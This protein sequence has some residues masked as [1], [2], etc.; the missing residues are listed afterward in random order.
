[1]VSIELLQFNFIVFSCL[2]RAY[3]R[4][5]EESLK[6]KYK[7]IDDTGSWSW[8][9]NVLDFSESLQNLLYFYSKHVPEFCGQFCLPLTP[10]HKNW[11]PGYALVTL[12]ELRGVHYHMVWKNVSFML[13]K[14]KVFFAITCG[15][16]VANK[17]T[18]QKSIDS[19]QA[20][21]NKWNAYSF[22]N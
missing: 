10:I 21:V 1:M 20:E 2:A 13:E 3:P 6:L 15:Q 11:D 18:E 22:Q 4:G 9:E 8:V 16:E 17:K 5:T 7:K 14:S 19:L 12:F